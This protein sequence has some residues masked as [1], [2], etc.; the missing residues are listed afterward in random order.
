ME[1]ERVLVIGNP[2]VALGATGVV[3]HGAVIVEGGRIVEVGPRA[4]L[5]L[6]GP[7]DATW[8]SD[9]HLVMPGFI[10]AHYHTEC[11]TAP[12]LIDEIFELGNLY[13][14]SGMIETDPEVISLLAT[15]GLV[16][17]LKGGQTTTVDAFDGRP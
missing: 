3:A 4:E 10:N 9:E 15:Y 7:F 12:G 13:V 5:E 6:H 14:G 11:W 2:V 8:G 17:A 1:N 16:Q